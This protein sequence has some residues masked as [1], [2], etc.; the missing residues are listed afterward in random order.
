MYSAPQLFCANYPARGLRFEARP[1]REGHAQPCAL[2]RDTEPIFFLRTTYLL[3]RPPLR[4][5]AHH[6]PGPTYRSLLPP[7]HNLPPP[8]PKL[9]P[10]SHSLSPPDISLL[11]PGHSLLPA[12]HSPFYHLTTLV[13]HAQTEDR[14]TRADPASRREFSARGRASAPPPL[15]LLFL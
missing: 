13:T 1:Q 4:S 2:S 5:F 10:P 9:P 11:P 7:D 6:L 14:A 3:G 8:D 12:G 15:Q